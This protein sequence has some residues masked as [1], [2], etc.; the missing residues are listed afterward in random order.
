M[1]RDWPAA[2]TTN[3][4][5][6]SRWFTVCCTTGDDDLHPVEAVGDER[7]VGIRVRHRPPARQGPPGLPGSWIAD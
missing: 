1:G 3:T 6:L 4:R 2:P 7:T 5:S